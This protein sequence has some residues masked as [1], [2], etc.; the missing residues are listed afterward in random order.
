MGQLADFIHDH[1]LRGVDPRPVL[2]EHRLGS[3]SLKNFLDPRVLHPWREDHF[4]GRRSFRGSLFWAVL[5]GVLGFSLR[6][7]AWSFGGGGV[8][9]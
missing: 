5:R 2:V 9:P 1:H 6:I 4:M 7:L 3:A 8:V